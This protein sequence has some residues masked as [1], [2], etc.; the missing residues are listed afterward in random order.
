MVYSEKNPPRCFHGIG[1][2]SPEQSG[3]PPVGNFMEVVKKKPHNSGTFCIRRGLLPG[4]HVLNV[5]QCEPQRVKRTVDKAP[6]IVRRFTG[7]DQGYGMAVFLCLT[8]Q[9]IEG[10]RR[11]RC[12]AYRGFPAPDMFPCP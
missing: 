9:E 11:A 1:E 8:E 7:A 5:F 6:D 10:L 4:G 3:N 2:D 12:R